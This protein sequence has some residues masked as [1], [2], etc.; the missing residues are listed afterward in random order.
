M[1]NIYIS[2][3]FVLASSQSRYIYLWI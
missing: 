2:V 1:D 3:L